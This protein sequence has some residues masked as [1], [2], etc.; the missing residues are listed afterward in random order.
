MQKI[1]VKDEV[2]VIAGKNKGKRGKV[3]Q[4]NH[5]NNKVLVEGI[6][7]AT[8][9]MARSKDNTEGG[10][11]KKELF[12]DRSNVALLDPKTGKKTRIKIILIDGIKQRVS[13]KSSAA[14]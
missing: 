7:L 3:K 6:N 14:I 13:V 2:I 1:K 11:V 9:A 10:F 4:I 8:K 5:K 12:I